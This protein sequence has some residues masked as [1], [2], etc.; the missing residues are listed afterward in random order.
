MSLIEEKVE[1]GV[2]KALKKL[3]SKFDLTPKPPKERKPRVSKEAA[4]KYKELSS[5]LVGGENVK[6]NL[7]V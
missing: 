3:Y 5:D 6:I 1:Q 2:D 4:D 7:K